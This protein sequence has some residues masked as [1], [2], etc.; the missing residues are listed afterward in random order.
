MLKSA[1]NDRASKIFSM[2]R[3]I[4]RRNVQILNIQISNLNFKLR[5]K[6]P[7][8]RIASHIRDCSRR[9]W[10]D[11]LNAIARHGKYSHRPICALDYSRTN[12]TMMSYE[13]AKS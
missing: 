9:W 5:F 3:H 6:S 7:A 11:A 13:I 4:L 2:R 1:A 12:A 10:N 8:N